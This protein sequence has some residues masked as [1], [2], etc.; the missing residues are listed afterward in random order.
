[1]AIHVKEVH[2]KQINAHLSDAE[3]KQAILE[4]VL[5][6]H[7]IGDAEYKHRTFITSNLHSTGNSYEGRCEI[8]IELA[9]DN[10]ASTTPNQA[11][12][13]QFQTKE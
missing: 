12:D 9:G 13:N 1:M 3:T 7:D 11:T 4:Y 10:E 5:R 8:T 2:Q 6:Q